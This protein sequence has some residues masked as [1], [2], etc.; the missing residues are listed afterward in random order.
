MNK[1]ITTLHTNK[2]TIAWGV[3]IL[4]MLIYLW[5]ANYYIVNIP[6][7]DDYDLALVFLDQYLSTEGIGNKLSLLFS[8]DNEHRI[9]TQRLLF[10]LDYSI[11]GELDFT[12]IMRF[13]NCIWIALWYFFYRISGLSI[14]QLLPVTFFIFVPLDR[15][16]NWEGTAFIH[17]SILLLSFLALFFLNRNTSK[18]FI[19]AII[20]AF[21]AT[22][23]LGNGMF[24]FIAGFLVLILQEPIDQK[25]LLI[26]GLGFVCFAGFYFYD[27][28]S[29][30]G[31]PSIIQTLLQ[32]PIAVMAYP[33]VF[34]GVIFKSL[35]STHQYAG[36]I[37]GMLTILFTLGLVYFKWN[38]IK[39]QPVLLAIL[40]L[41]LFTIGI[42]ALTRAGFGIGQATTRR[43]QL[44][45]VSFYSTLYIICFLLFKDYFK[46]RM[47]I[48]LALSLL[49]YYFRLDD[50]IS[51]LKIQQ[52][53]LVT[54]IEYYEAGNPNFLFYP[55]P[56]SA[57]QMME[58]S[59]NKGQF[60]VD[61]SQDI[62]PD[63][64]LS[65]PLSDATTN[66]RLKID[67]IRNNANLLAVKGWAILHRQH[68]TLQKTYLVLQSDTDNFMFSTNLN[69]RPDIAKFLISNYAFDDAG[70]DIVLNKK[71]LDIPS[72]NYKIGV[73]IKLMN[74]QEGLFF[75]K[76]NTTF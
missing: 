8:Q 50:S 74:G 59:I 65:V 27:Y 63:V 53:R 66:G 23:T 54:S 51:L 72:G 71:A 25:K 14:F 76:K 18:A 41:L 55:S 34:L 10:I 12:H 3:S 73:Y 29:P 32:Q 11:F 44:M 35:Y 52:N 9:M 60:T 49:L 16:V 57:A 67:D 47:G 42:A 48:I 45:Q 43:Y 58:N 17:P 39:K 28:N 62:M 5:V 37:I 40:A 75:S 30:S 38:H 2:N 31:H 21:F 1:L 36:P 22:F 56:K 33:C 6:Y 61:N 4:L 15:I 19:L 70:F 13:G 68:S 64:P 20:C 46:N 26:W 7:W 24:V 69:K